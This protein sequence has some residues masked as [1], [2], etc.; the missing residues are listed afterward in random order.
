MRNN[1]HE[2][3]LVYSNKNI[4]RLRKFITKARIASSLKYDGIET[5]IKEYV[6]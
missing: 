2:E 4:N 1:I 5:A 6:G 3:R